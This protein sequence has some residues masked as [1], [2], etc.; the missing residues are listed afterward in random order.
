M[1]PFRNRLY[2]RH[3]LCY[4]LLY[5]VLVGGVILISVGTA[6]LLD[7]LRLIDFILIILGNILLL[8][9]HYILKGK[10]EK[11]IFN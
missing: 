1:T 4:A 9:Y 8:A 2:H 3:P 6:G 11:M 7:G 5:Y 10:F